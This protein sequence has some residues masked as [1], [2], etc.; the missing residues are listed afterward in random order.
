M[1]WASPHEERTYRTCQE[2]AARLDATL[3]ALLA[4]LESLRGYDLERERMARQQ[5]V[6]RRDVALVEERAQLAVQ[7]ANTR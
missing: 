5:A 6:M 2:T 1:Y 7:R 3:T 4:Y